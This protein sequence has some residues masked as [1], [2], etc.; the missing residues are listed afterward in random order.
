[1]QS[2]RLLRALL[3]SGIR[4]IE[5]AAHACATSYQYCAGRCA[6]WRPPAWLWREKR[7]EVE[8]EDLSGNLIVQFGAVTEDLNRQ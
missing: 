2:E 4:V 1:L 7:G 6:T 3:Y 5:V 8:P